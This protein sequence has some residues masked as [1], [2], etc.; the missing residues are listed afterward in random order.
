[1][2]NNLSINDIAKLANVSKA[3][4]S[5]VLNNKEGVSDKTRQKVLDVIEQTNYK[6][7]LNSRRLFYRKSFTIAVVFD[8]ISSTLN[9]LFYYDI[10][11]SLVK[12]CMSYDY[13]LVHYEY[14]LIDNQLTLPE[15]ILN[16]DVD[17]LIFLKDIPMELVAKLTSLDIPFVVADDHSEHRSLHS[18][19]VDY[20]LAAY[21]AVQYLISQ[22][23]KNIGFIGNMNLPS[24]YTQVFSGYQK[25]LR[26]ANLPLKPAWCYEKILDR[27]TM[28]KYISDM[29][30]LKELP[31]AVFCIE[32]ILAIELIRYLHKRGLQVPED[33]SVIS[34]DDIILSNMIYPGL[35]TVVLDKEKIGNCAVDM[36]ID[37][38]NH[39]EVQ[40]TVIASSDIIVRDS[41][42]KM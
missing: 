15:N 13:A 30:E 39:R 22:G 28:E 11:N 33:I 27:E 35:T 5:F 7:S 1:M 14:S 20:R 6:P 36:L 16:K 38:I 10:M 19:K 23:H 8:K 9:N 18:V 24:F 42:K 37:L 17:G 29:L 26:E 12:R 2:K 34:I 40:N 31:T 25:A 4:V 32:D 21:S 41:V 3:T